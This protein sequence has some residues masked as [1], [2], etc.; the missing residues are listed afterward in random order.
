M[1]IV[2]YNGVPVKRQKRVGKNLIRVT[3]YDGQETIFV[4][5]E[6]WQKNSSNR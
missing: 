5:F 1:R 6:E 4:T 3:F 2:E